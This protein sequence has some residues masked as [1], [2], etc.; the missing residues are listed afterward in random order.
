MAD[1]PLLMY[2]AAVGRAGRAAYTAAGAGEQCYICLKICQLWDVLAGQ[3]IQR[4]GQVNSLAYGCKE[5]QY[6]CMYGWPAVAA[7]YGSR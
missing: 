2:M 7:V 3:P 5:G 4:L 1:L 6:T